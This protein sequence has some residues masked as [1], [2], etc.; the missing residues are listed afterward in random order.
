MSII[1]PR[2]LLQ[3]YAKLALKSI[4]LPNLKTRV[5]RER[6]QPRTSD[7]YNYST[8]TLSIDLPHYKIKD[9]HAP[10][11]ILQAATSQ[12]VCSRAISE[13]T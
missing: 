12:S 13:S 3:L 8:T 10:R 7:F 11:K 4:F 6:P 2:V 9:C 1:F 5:G